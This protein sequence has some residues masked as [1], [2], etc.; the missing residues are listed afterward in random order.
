MLLL[1]NPK[2]ALFVQKQTLFLPQKPH[3]KGII[4]SI[5]FLPWTGGKQFVTGG[6]DHAVVL[7]NEIKDDDW[8]PTVL[9][10]SLH[11]SAVMGVAGLFHRKW[12]LSSGA[13]KRVIAFDPATQ[14]AP[15]NHQ[16]DS[17]AISVVPNPIDHNMYMVQ[18]GLVV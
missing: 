2:P 18:T 10:R 13:D 9:H 7:W 6:C 5:K 12:V 1:L 11:T 3:E 16:L 17:R 15:H 4:N 14:R 8:H